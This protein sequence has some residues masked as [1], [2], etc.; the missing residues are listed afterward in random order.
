MDDPYCN[1]K[2]WISCLLNISKSLN[3][4]VFRRAQLLFANRIFGRT[5]VSLVVRAAPSEVS[6]VILDL[7]IVNSIAAT[8]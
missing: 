6:S 4:K 5:F 2:L 3:N 8:R 1:I 7:M